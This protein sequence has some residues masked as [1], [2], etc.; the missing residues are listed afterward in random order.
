MTGRHLR[1]ECRHREVYGRG[2]FSLTA[3][4]ARTAEADQ[5]AARTSERESVVKPVIWRF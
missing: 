2:A 3:A 4:E 1:P 5:A